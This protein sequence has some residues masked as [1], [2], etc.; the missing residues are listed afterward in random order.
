VQHRPPML[1]SLAWNGFN[2]QAGFPQ[3]RNRA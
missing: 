3:E 2:E 1:F